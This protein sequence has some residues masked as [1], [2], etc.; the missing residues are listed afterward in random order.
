MRKLLTFLIALGAIVFAIVSPVSAQGFNGGGFNMGLGPFASGGFAGPGDV[1]SGA[2]FYYGF[3]CYNA[4]YAGNVA[5][6]VDTATGTTSGTRLQCSAGGTIS[7]VVSASTC[8]TTTGGA[9]FISGGL[10]SP[11]ATTCAVSCNVLTTYDQSGA[12]ACVSGPCDLTMPTLANQ[13]L[14]VNSCVNSKPCMKF[15]A[16]DLNSGVTNTLT[17]AQ[18]FTF[19]Q[20]MGRTGNFTNFNITTLEGGQVAGVYFGSAANRI[21]LIAGSI[22]NF[23]DA[24]NCPNTTTLSVHGIING[25]SSLIVCGGT[26][27]GA[28][29]PGTSTWS[30]QTIHIGSDGVTT[31]PC[32]CTITVSGLWPI[33]MNSTQYNALHANYQTY[34]AVP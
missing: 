7:A 22:V 18:P 4:A 13:P 25:A 28:L 34:W 10:C 16:S 15:V 20:V 6:L 3:E 29:N 30:G 31:N 24:T 14:Y 23:T 32:T 8:A 9:A 26:D 17:L 27:S 19:S 2:K 12:A 5:D 33:A 11:I 21:S 1:L